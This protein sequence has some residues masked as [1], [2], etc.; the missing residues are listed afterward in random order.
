LHAAPQR[1]FRPGRNIWPD[2]SFSWRA[3]EAAIYSPRDTPAR[4]FSGFPCHFLFIARLNIQYLSRLLPV[5]RWI[6]HM[7]RDT[8]SRHFSLVI[9]W[10]GRDRARGGTTA[11]PLT[12]CRY[13]GEIE[14]HRRCLRKYWR[15][16]WSAVQMIE[17]A[18]DLPCAKKENESVVW[19]YWLSTWNFN[20]TVISEYDTRKFESIETREQ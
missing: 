3:L 13:V 20:N 16:N 14:I 7:H 1:R 18:L 12:G 8:S 6:T 19:I 5:S 11:I 9:V 15:W 2:G 17:I 4:R 10:R